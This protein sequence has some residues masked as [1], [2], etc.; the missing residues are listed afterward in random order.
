MTA[1]QI[2]SARIGAVTGR[3]IAA[4]ART[5]YPRPLLFGLIALLCGANIINIAADLAAMGEALQMLTGGP[6]HVYAAAFGLFCL[7]FE[8]FISYRR[9]A[10]YLKGLTL[11]L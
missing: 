8:V 9:Y 4:N 1:I 3:G 10:P 6:P 2:I 5:I 11:A 7:V